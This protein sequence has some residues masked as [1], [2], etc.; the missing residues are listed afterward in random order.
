M[1]SRGRYNG[2]DFSYSPLLFWTSISVFV[3]SVMCS[4]LVGFNS[5]NTLNASHLLY[6]ANLFDCFD[7]CTRFGN[8]KACNFLCVRLSLII[9]SYIIASAHSISFAFIYNSAVNVLFWWYEFRMKIHK[10]GACECVRCGVEW[11]RQKEVI[12]LLTSVNNKFTLNTKLMK[13]CQMEGIA[14][15]SGLIVAEHNCWVWGG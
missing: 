2:G 3:L 5:L 14:D 7:W 11:G 15:G 10:W 8:W 12:K 4:I 13:I 9:S 1:I 6:A